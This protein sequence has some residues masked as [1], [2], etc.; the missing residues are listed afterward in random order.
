MQKGIDVNADSK[1][2]H[3]VSCCNW[4]KHGNINYISL[5][6]KWIVNCDFF[7]IFISTN[8]VFNW[9]FIHTVVNVYWLRKWIH[10]F[11]TRVFAFYTLKTNTDFEN[12]QYWLRKWY[13]FFLNSNALTRFFLVFFLLDSANYI[14]SFQL[15]VWLNTLDMLSLFIW[16]Y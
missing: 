15:G 1:E 4:T 14:I 6:K 16:I 8:S 10:S 3:V 13:I 12:D 11:C 9:F 5:L 2:Y 7:F